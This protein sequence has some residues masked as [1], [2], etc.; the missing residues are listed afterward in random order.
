MKYLLLLQICL[1]VALQSRAQS[2]SKIK[3]LNLGEQV[4]NIKFEF[5]ANGSFKSTSIEDHRGKWLILGFWSMYCPPCIKNFPN[6]DSLQQEFKNSLTI[7]LVN[8]DNSV[9][10]EEVICSFLSKWEHRNKRKLNLPTIYKD[11]IARILFNCEYAPH[12][13]WIT[14]EGKLL[15]L[16][17]TDEIN[18]KQIINVLENEK[19]QLNIKNDVDIKHPLFAKEILPMEQLLQHSVF[20]K[21]YYH[22]LGDSRYS[23]GPGE[24]PYGLNI[25]NQSLLTI[26]KE[27]AHRMDNSI[28]ENRIIID[29][30]NEKNQLTRDS[31][32]EDLNTSIYSLGVLVPKN[33]PESLF[34]SIFETINRYT[35]YSVLL[36]TR[37]VP[38]Y[39]LVYTGKKGALR[40][41]GSSSKSTLY[42]LKN[43][44]L[45]NGS[46]E[47]I[48]KIL[49]Q[50][51]EFKLPVV[52][53]T[54]ISFN[55][56][57][58][59]DRPLREL[60]VIAEELRKYNLELRPS[61]AQLKVLVIRRK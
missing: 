34:P 29:T 37:K 13:A 59:F 49:N 50:V 8:I 6:M 25:A 33:Q 7:M 60:N 46:I 18:R 47:K 12:Y 19:T 41:D 9:S 58:Y 36:E 1:T 39:A 28:T 15:A 3:P 40:S 20:I 55:V 17:G 14:P 30:D 48:V 53:Q 21:G 32:F 2:D 52:N 56:D 11:S 24:K 35:D 57:L 27:V 23:F 38:C 31:I 45:Q 51:P 4:P 16:T 5:V 61:S 54:G 44:Y 43:P 26:V 42:S 22:G 10:S